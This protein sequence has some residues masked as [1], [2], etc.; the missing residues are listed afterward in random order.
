MSISQRIAF[1]GGGNMAAALIHGLLATHTT[2]ADQLI[3]CDVLPESLTRLRDRHGIQTSTDN[4][5]ARDAGVVVLSVKPQVFPTLLPELAPLLSERSLVISIAAGVPLQAIEAWLPKSR[6]VRAMPNT[7]ALASA[8]ATAIAPGERARDEDLAIAR[9]LF[10][11]V[12]RVVQVDEAQMDAVTA[13]SGSGPAYVFLMAEAMIEAATK[14]GLP[15]DV[16]TT[17][18]LQTIFGAGKLLAESQDG[19][20]ELR[21]KVTSPGGTTAAGLEALEHGHFRAL[22]EAC[23]DAARARGAELGAEVSAKLMPAVRS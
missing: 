2:R 5:R 6:V 16:A 20:A 13:L 11:S 8:G 12:G 19:A 7:P 15:R 3:A 18:T 4:A 23:L 10:A 21:R 1:I 17:L 14:I 9:A 22:I